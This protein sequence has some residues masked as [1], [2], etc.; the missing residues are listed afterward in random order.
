MAPTG[1]ANEVTKKMD[2][3]LE[4]AAVQRSEYVAFF[5]FFLSSLFL[6]AFLL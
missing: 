2:F 5:F 6:V 3:G 1:H 4:W